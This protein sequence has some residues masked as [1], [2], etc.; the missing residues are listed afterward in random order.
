MPQNIVPLD[1]RIFQVRGQAVMLDSDLA[2]V[3]GVETKR[4][5]EAVKRNP[6]RFPP[7]Y[8][9]QLTQDEWD[10]LRSQIATLNTG[11]GQH[12]KY[13]PQMFT[14]HGA[15]MLATV[16]NSDRAIQASMAVV[17]AFIRIRHVLDVH[18]DLARKV[19]ELAA[20]VGDHG[21]AIALIFNALGWLTQGQEPEPPKE[22]IGFK[23]NK[24]RGISG[25]SCKK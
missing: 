6:K 19:D 22:R 10:A 18:R 5:N 11:R 3:Y 13:L 8:T 12:R 14:E 21:Q 16:L 7:L 24:E 2:A 20:Q 9:F 15:V 17:E 4:V 25:K 23:P 1:S